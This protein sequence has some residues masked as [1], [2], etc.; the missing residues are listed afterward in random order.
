MLNELKKNKDAKGRYIYKFS[1]ENASNDNQ[2]RWNCTRYF[3]DTVTFEGNINKPKCN[4]DVIG[5]ITETITKDFTKCINTTP[6]ESNFLMNA[7]NLLNLQ[8]LKNLI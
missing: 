1:Y 3:T 2:N 7:L 8:K 5:G 6:R 4:K